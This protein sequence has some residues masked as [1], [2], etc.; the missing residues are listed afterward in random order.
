MQRVACTAGLNGEHGDELRKRAH[1]AVNRRAGEN[2][3]QP[4]PCTA[5]LNG[6]HG[7]ELQIHATQSREQQD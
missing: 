5:A 4:V 7:D 1:G 2:T 6:E 3:V